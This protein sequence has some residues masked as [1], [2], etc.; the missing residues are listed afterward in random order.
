MYNPGPVTH[1]YK[2]TNKEKRNKGK[3]PIN[4]HIFQDLQC[5]QRVNNEEVAKPPQFL[6]IVLTIFYMLQDLKFVY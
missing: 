5:I 1:F 4:I 6:F 2:H 3:P